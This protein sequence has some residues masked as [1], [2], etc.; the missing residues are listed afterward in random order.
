V[1]L[2]KHNNGWEYNVPPSEDRLKQ[3]AGVRYLK[4]VNII[5]L[6]PAF[7]WP[8]ANCVVRAAILTY[9]SGPFL[10]NRS[11]VTLPVALDYQKNL[12]IV[13]KNTFYLKGAA[14][15]N[16]L[17]DIGIVRQLRM[18]SSFICYARSQ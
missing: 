17:R 1:F 12:S 2:C 9:L 6:L 10:F 11:P 14:Q 13:T 4:I 8:M 16:I 3:R 18:R 5:L 15:F 7:R